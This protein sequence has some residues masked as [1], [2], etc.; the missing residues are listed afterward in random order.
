MYFI[1]NFKTQEQYEAYKASS[2]WITPNLCSIVANNLV[3]FQEY[4][5][6]KLCDIAY[7]SNNDG[8]IKTI[9][10]SEWQADLG[11]PIGIVVIPENFLPDG[12]ARIVAL[13]NLSAHKWVTDTST[14]TSSLTSYGGVVTTDNQTNTIQALTASGFYPSDKWKVSSGIVS[15]VDSEAYYN[16]TSTDKIPSPYFNNKLNPSFVEDE[17]RYTNALSDFNGEFNTSALSNLGSPAASAATSYSFGNL[18]WYLPSLGELA[19]VG[20]RW[21]AINATRTIL[22]FNSMAE[23]GYWSSTKGPDATAWVLT[24]TTRSM[25][26]KNTLTN[27]S[28][29]L[30][31]AILENPHSYK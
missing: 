1:K 11:E 28:F 4:D 29:V 15:D 6:F 22:G 23:V 27:T 19:F 12:K 3:L 7:L 20:V 30:P 14:D 9:K 13:N 17:P 5:S 10:A 24:L 16:N 25:I 18:H 31:F 21:S 8:K 26:T 2:E